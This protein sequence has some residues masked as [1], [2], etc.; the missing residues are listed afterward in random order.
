MFDIARVQHSWQ[1]EVAALAQVAQRLSEAEARAPIREDEWSTQDVLAHLTVS[2]REF[3]AIVSHP[4]ESRAT[5]AD[6]AERDAWNEAQRVRSAE[7]S[8]SDTW[9]RWETTATAVTTLLAGLAADEAAQPVS[10]TWLPAVASVGDVL[11]I[12]IIHT[13][14]HRM[15]LTNGLQALAMRNS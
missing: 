3:A 2:N 1:T 9:E 8:W 13:R 11:R 6:E 14:S 15:E 4:A 7:R 5:F 10:L 12:M